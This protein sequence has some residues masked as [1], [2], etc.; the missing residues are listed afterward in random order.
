MSGRPLISYDDITLPYD[1]QRSTNPPP[2]PP[3]A[4]KAKKTNSNNA[5]RFNHP[6]AT[7]HCDDP[8]AL[9]SS[10]KTAAASKSSTTKPSSKLSAPGKS[11]SKK[12]GTSSW[13]AKEESRELTQEEIWDDSALINAWDAAMEEYEAFNGPDKSWK[14]EPVFKS[15][16]WYN[17]PPSAR[18]SHSDLPTQDSV[19][20]S[21]SALKNGANED[22][23][24]HEYD[25]Y[26]GEA[27]E[28]APGNDNEQ[29]SDEAAQWPGYSSAYYDLGNPSSSMST[30]HRDFAKKRKQ[31]PSDENDEAEE[32]VNANDGEEDENYGM[33]TS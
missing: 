32:G 12:G 28:L 8:K 6:Q 1:P 22:E 9:S 18:P 14:N 13:S 10:S 4:K 17:V 19:D 2:G 20:P 15:P 25:D 26:Y 24:G 11:P 31:P 27:E 16:L 30:C 23:G 21:S 7:G 3:P 5:T 29:T 33:V